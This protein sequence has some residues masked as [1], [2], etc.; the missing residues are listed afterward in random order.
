MRRTIIWVA[1][2]VAAAVGL[3]GCGFSV[4]NLPLPGGTNVGSNPLTVQVQFRDVL[5]LVPD[6]AVKVDDVSVGNVKTI[7]LKNGIAVVTVQLRR[8]TKL[9]ANATASI[10]QTSLLGEKFVNLKTP[11]DPSAQLLANGATIPLARTGTNPQIEDVLGALSLVLNGGGVAQLKTIATE[12]NKALGGH[13]DAARSVIT[14]VNTLMRN[15]D[16]NK[17]SIVQ[18]ISSLD[19]LSVN[20]QHQEKTIDATLEE[21]PAAVRSINGQRQQLVTMLRALDRL[22]KTGTRVILA[23]KTN[24]IAIIRDLQ[25]TLTELA[26]TG[27][28]FVNAFNTLLSY[29]FVDAAVGNSPEVARN[30][31][32]GDYVNLDVTL[33][34]DFSTLLG[35]KGHPPTLLPPTVAPTKVVS[36][37][38]Q[39]IKSG[40]LTSQACK[41]VLGSV[42]AL[43]NLMNECKKPQNENT[44]VCQLLNQVPG[45]PSLNPSQTGGA[46]PSSLLPSLPILGGLSS[47]KRA[48]ESLSTRGAQPISI[49]ELDALYDPNLVSLMVPGLDTQERS[50]R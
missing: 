2:L 25:P 35:S 43:T 34:L 49:R 12:L 38:L 7:D 10:E 29:P 39:C 19:R 24:T 28:H 5:D 41:D 4:Y 22:G 37:V 18:A 23:S 3:G 31:R 32:M 26:A 30:L 6:S 40:S 45:L 48:P 33:N 15:L 16:D 13:E 27:N 20:V 42:Q 1:A 47:D 8:D 50:A 44:T 21:L 14:Q 9:P 36:E 46:V 11:P 17:Q